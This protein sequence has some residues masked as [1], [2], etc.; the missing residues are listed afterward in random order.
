MSASFTV[1]GS[2]SD[3]AQAIHAALR[4]LASR[5]LGLAGG[6][7]LPGTN[8]PQRQN[9][10]QRIRTAT[11]TTLRL[12]MLLP[13]TLDFGALKFYLKCSSLLVRH[14]AKWWCG[15]FGRLNL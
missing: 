6:R 3:Q 7:G 9:T 10:L 14:F 1:L 4:P 8:N 12:R 13:V 11:K 15:C 2:A 5:R